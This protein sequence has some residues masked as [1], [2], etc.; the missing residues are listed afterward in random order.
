MPDFLG[1]VGLYLIRGLG[2][3]KRPTELRR[4]GGAVMPGP[5]AHDTQRGQWQPRA[6]VRDY[7]R[8]KP[9][10]MLKGTYRNRPP[11]LTDFQ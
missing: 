10:P 9:D 8:I 3:L 5:G 1:R 2:P 6:L 7:R 11:R 4:G